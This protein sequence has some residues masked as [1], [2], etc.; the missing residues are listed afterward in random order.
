M[1]REDV[2]G[3][4]YKGI[5]ILWLGKEKEDDLKDEP[6]E[7]VSCPDKP[8]SPKKGGRQRKTDDLGE[9]IGRV[10]A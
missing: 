10:S 4:N 5:P 1:L 6:K 2:R 8:E 7:K 9:P 3:H